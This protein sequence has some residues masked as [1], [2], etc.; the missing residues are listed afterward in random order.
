MELAVYRG[1]PYPPTSA[2]RMLELQACTPTSS[3]SRDILKLGRRHKVWCLTCLWSMAFEVGKFPDG[4]WCQQMF[5]LWSFL[6]ETESCYVTTEA[7]L[8]HRPFCLSRPGGDGLTGV[9]HP[10]SIVRIVFREPFP[11]SPVLLFSLFSYLFCFLSFFSR[12]F[13]NRAHSLVDILDKT[14]YPSP[15]FVSESVWDR[16]QRA[17]TLH[18]EPGQL[19]KLPWAS[20]WGQNSLHSWPYLGLADEDG[21]HLAHESYSANGATFSGSLAAQVM[22]IFFLALDNPIWYALGCCFNIFVCF[23]VFCIQKLSSEPFQFDACSGKNKQ[24]PDSNSHCL[25]YCIHNIVLEGF[26]KHGTSCL[27]LAT[28]TR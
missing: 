22:L 4:C 11:W 13:G 8:K 5:P 9:C 12:S 19:A 16:R 27:T 15:V 24:A 25:F 7:G 20:K 28:W 6:F 10:P 17:K 1:E 3:S 21:N 18:W 2:S 23:N 14:Q 26:H